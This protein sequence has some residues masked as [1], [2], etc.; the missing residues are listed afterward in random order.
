MRYVLLMFVLSWSF[1]VSAEDAA[2]AGE[3][4]GVNLAQSTVRFTVVQGG[5]PFSGRFVTFG[6]VLCRSNNGVARIDVWLDPGS[7]DSGLPEVDQLLLTP[8]FFDVARH[9]RVT[10]RSDEIVR[11]GMLVEATGTLTIN[12]ISRERSVEFRFGESDGGWQARGRFT[13][14]RLTYELGTGEWDNTEYLANEVVVEFDA[15]L[16][17]DEHGNASNE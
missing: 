3:V 12:G 17:P 16:V 6:G 9:P 4:L 11:Q 10:F 15:M 13:L 5:A 8:Q 14:P 7:V 1:T 2:C